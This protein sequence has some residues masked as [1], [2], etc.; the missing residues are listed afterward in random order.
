MRPAESSSPIREET[1]RASESPDLQSRE[2]TQVR[3]KQETR[4]VRVVR[5]EG[6]TNQS[7]ASPMPSSPALIE[8]IIAPKHNGISEAFP[9]ACLPE[10]NELIRR[11]L[12]PPNRSGSLGRLKN[13][14]V[15]E[16]IGTVAAGAVFRVTDLD[17]QRVVAIKAMLPR[18]GADA[19]A[20]ARFIS[21]GRA[22]AALAHENLIGIHGVG[23][24]G[25]I[26]YLVMEYAEG[27]SLAQRLNE[28]G[29]LPPSEV[30]RIG[31]QAAA[32][33]SAAHAAG[34]VHRDVKPANLLLETS[35][36][37]VKVADFGLAHRLDPAG[38][39]VGEVVGTPYFMSPEQAAGL[40]TDPRSDLFSL[41]CVLYLCCPGELPFPG[42]SI[43]TVLE[44]I[45]SVMPRPVRQVDPTL[46]DWLEEIIFGLLAKNPA[47]RFPATA[48][49]VKMQLISRW[50]S[51]F[52]QR[53]K[54]SS[55][56]R[57]CASP[58]LLRDEGGEGDVRGSRQGAGEGQWRRTN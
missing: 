34:L 48:N 44:Q 19:R 28:K 42:E 37:R 31:L 8:T 1:I 38:G 10:L 39:Q 41:G 17:L 57:S 2:T 14:E 56:R 29:R 22:V 36:G 51:L 30:V 49:E 7:K 43:E 27:G 16:L 9:P 21:E 18:H 35:T 20:R 26:P 40:F 46:P 33:L 11:L 25:G 45:F 24:A 32:G 52:T 3:R 6:T 47:D 50:A 58:L 23:E 12:N 54:T 5:I 55:M 13:Y 53:G 4:R 15:L